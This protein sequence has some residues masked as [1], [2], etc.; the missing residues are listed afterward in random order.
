MKNSVVIY[1]SQVDMIKGVF[2]ADPEKQ[3]AMYDAIFN[4]VFNDEQP[5]FND[6]VMQG[7]WC[8]ILPCID[9]AVARYQA[10]VENGKKGAKYGK[11]GGR[12]KK[13][14]TKEEYQARKQQEKLKR[15]Q[16][17]KTVE[18][19]I[20]KINN[21]ISNE[22][23]NIYPSTFATLFAI[24]PTSVNDIIADQSTLSNICDRLLNDFT[25]EQ[26]QDWVNIKKAECKK[27]LTPR[28]NERLV[29]DNI[30]END[31]PF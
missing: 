8:G 3:L 11:D 24:S 19:Y 17:V 6:Y 1:K 15:K 28:D 29:A 23:C 31:M 13:G 12:P 21:I 7:V 26:V 27:E 9:K 20:D 4:Y 25:T 30:D 10:S 18:N 2:N 22:Y 16:D 14:E 5:I